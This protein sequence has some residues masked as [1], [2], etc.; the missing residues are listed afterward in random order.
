MN[1]MPPVTEA[2]EHL[3]LPRFPNIRQKNRPTSP[4]IVKNAQK[5]TFQTPKGP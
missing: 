1:W 5:L 4:Q 3:K 2:L